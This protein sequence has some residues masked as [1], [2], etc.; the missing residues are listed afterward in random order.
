M[1]INIEIIKRHWN[2]L[3]SV[4]AYNSIMSTKVL[5]MQ[6]VDSQNVKDWLV[7]ANDMKLAIVS[8]YRDLFGKEL[9][10]EDICRECADLEKYIMA[11]VTYP[12]EEAHKSL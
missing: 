3:E 11:P 2:I 5:P 7:V 9:S 12:E 8:E 4:R 1:Q 6:G 10:F